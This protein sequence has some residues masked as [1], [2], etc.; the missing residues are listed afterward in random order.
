M[1]LILA[2]KDIVACDAIAGKV[3]GYEPDEVVITKFAAKRGMD[4]M[5]LDETEVK[6]CAIDEVK[7]RFKRA[8]EVCR[9]LNCYLPKEPAQAVKIQF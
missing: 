8:S 1:G 5:D 6:G 3:M 4:V 2:S 7:R 9:L